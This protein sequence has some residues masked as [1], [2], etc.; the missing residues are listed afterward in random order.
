MQLHKT[1][2]KLIRISSHVAIWY[3]V[4]DCEQP[5]AESDQAA[6]YNLRQ[7]PLNDSFFVCFWKGQA[8]TCFTK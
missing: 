8:P 7:G 5:T 2:I 1:H 4:T 6:V 3:T